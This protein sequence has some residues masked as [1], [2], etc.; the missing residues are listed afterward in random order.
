MRDISNDSKIIDD[1]GG[2][3]VLCEKLGYSKEKGGVQRI[4]NWKR[5]GIPASV[6]LQNQ[7]IFLVGKSSTQE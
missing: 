6:I 5:R 4:S 7:Q 3:A 2:P 1:L